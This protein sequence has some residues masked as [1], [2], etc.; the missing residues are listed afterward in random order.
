VV[1][2]FRPALRGLAVVLSVVLMSSLTA[3]PAMA[4][5]TNAADFTYSQTLTV[6]N[7]NSTALT[8][9]QVKVSLT[10]SNFDFAEAQSAGQDLRFYAS[11]GATPL[12]FWTAS[13]S[14]SA[15][16]ATIW[17]EVPSIPAAGSTTIVMKWGN[18]TAATASDGFTTFPFF[19]DFSDPSTQSD[20]FNL[21]A[22]TTELV[23]DQGFENSGPHTMSVMNLNLSGYQYYSYYGPQGD[24][25]IGLAASNNLTSWTELGEVTD[26]SGTWANVQ[27]RWPSAVVVGSTIYVAITEN[28]STLP[29]YIAL[30]EAPVSNPSQL[31]RVETLISPQGGTYDQNPY[32]WLDPNNG[33]F[34]IYW[35]SDSDGGWSILARTASSVPALA[36]APDIEVLHSSGTL[37][38][39]N[40]MYLN[41]TYYLGTEIEPASTWET[42]FYSSTTSPV[43]GFQ[44]MA[45][46]PELPNGDAC[47]SQNAVGGT[48]YL[49]TCNQNSNTGV[50]TIDVRTANLTA[51]P[52]TG[53]TPNSSAWTASGGSSWQVG[54][55][56]LPN[57]TTGPAAEGTTSS[58]FQILQ[59]TYKTGANYVVDAYGQQV[60]GRVWGLGV[61]VK[62]AQDLDSV[63]L[64][65]DLNG[66]DN[67]YTYKWSSANGNNA[68]Q[69]ADAAVG[70]VNANQWYDMT[71][72]V[73]GTSIG[74]YING[75]LESQGTDPSLAAGSIALYGEAGTEEFADVFVRQ[76]A[77]TD[78]TVTFSGSTLLPQ[79]I[80]FTSTVPSN[81]TVG[82]AKYTVTAT[83]GASGNPVL[84]TIASASSAVCSIS[85]AVVSFTGAGTC[86]IDANQAGNSTYNPATQAQQ[87]FTVSSGSTG[88]FAYNET[89]TVNNPNSAALTNFQTKVSLTSS[90]FNFAEA[91]SGG[92]DLRF[93]ASNGTTPLNFWIASY[94]PTSQTGT[95]WVEVPSIAANGSTA[96]VMKWGNSTATTASNGTATFPLF[97]NFSEGAI[98]SSTWTASGGTWKVANTTLPNGSTGPVA[99]GTTAS[100]FQMLESTYKTGSSYVLDADGEQVSG[101]VWGLGV[102]VTD[103]KD[104]DSVN[105]Y[106]DL[107]GA[108]NLYMY[109]WTSA[110]SNSAT[111]IADAAVGTVNA[112]QWYDVTA[113]VAGTS[114]AVYLNGALEAQGTDSA[115]AA[116]SVALYG[117][118]GT[119]EF[120]DVFVRQ[121][122]ATDPTVTFPGSGL[123]AQ[124]ITFTSSAPTSATVGGATY[125]V[126]ATGGASGN[127]VLF[128]I[129]TASSAVCS[130]SGAVVSF[131][132]PGTCTIDANQAGN[133]TYNAAPQAQQSFTVSSTSTGFAYSQTLTVNNPNSTALTNFQT[134]V[135]LT[136]SNFEFAEAQS[137]GQDLRF[138]ASNGTTALNFWIAGYSA[139]SQTATIWVEV[140]SIAA[141]GSTAIVM[142]WGNS[143]ATTASSG[144]ATFPFFDNFSEG[145]ISSSTWTASGGTWKVANATQPGGSTGP[146]AEGTTASPFQIL[147]STYKT[148]SSYVL[149]ANGEQVSGRVWGLGVGVTDAKDLDS[150]NLYDDLNG[151]DNLYM[152]KW[153]STN[154]SSATTITDAAVGAVNATTWYDLT[155]KVNGTSIAVYLNGALEAQGTDSKLTAGSIALYGEAGSQ[156]F[157][158]VFVRQYAATDPTVTF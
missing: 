21:S 2:F 86:T 122:A 18:S 84:F 75:Q 45:D 124:T 141:N 55:T 131:T 29:S 27:S 68:T 121:Y 80:T 139:T 36:N 16:T 90:N 136:S 149:D 54:N 35:Y 1:R 31:T 105:L 102:G 115:L 62:D 127:P 30:Y 152:Y 97:D 156:E 138:Y 50:W 22:P 107:N 52:P 57:G 143:T 120:A 101:R 94:S 46:S 79:T 69:I 63:N 118:A 110:N 129:A 145:T 116:G 137:G 40:M 103:A 113:K 61:G 93:Y 87:S 108:D 92:Q 146:V 28:Y 153:T 9:F 6:S 60:A 126:A 47:P 89:L 71:A 23:Q 13:Y 147:E 88:T 42:A 48:L 140:P 38:A 81:A 111:T 119:E 51:P 104:L 5:D 157:S 7:S 128:N 83:G 20:Y 59:S 76:Y 65:D 150:V 4:A 3:V 43:S 154:A 95:V 49:Y 130:M 96:I 77:A 72:K 125:T 91:Q 151:T 37:A 67:L 19:D 99:E 11:D 10:S 70:T 148:G 74:V 56:T 25:W 14:S 132:G 117:E 58:P 32:L 41:G 64:Y 133:S 142:K 144:T 114:V 26:E 12:N 15:Q 73:A 155:A 85:G 109:K 134:K 33:Q 123:I 66:T 34:Y 82:G 106:D 8:N 39:P 100:P 98:S 78:P 24:G 44:P 158:N 112:N 53:T 17:V 135:A